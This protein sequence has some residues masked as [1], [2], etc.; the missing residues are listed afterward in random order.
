[1]APA[2]TAPNWS[3]RS[4]NLNV[5]TSA[6]STTSATTPASGQSIPDF[7]STIVPSVLQPQHIEHRVKPGRAALAPLH[8]LQGTTRKDHAVGRLVHELDALVGAG[9]DHAVF[10]R[11][12]AA[13]QD[14]KADVP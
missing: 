3:P 7:S 8:R 11:D 2:M 10:A 6:T 14:R 13:A 9:E 12:R 5:A 1:M 4:P